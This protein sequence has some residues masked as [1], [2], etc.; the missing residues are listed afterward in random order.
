MNPLVSVITPC[1]NAGEKIIK[2]LDSLLEQTYNNLEIIIVDNGSIDNTKEIVISYK[3]IF[4]E[5]GY[6]FVLLQEK[7]RGADNALNLGLKFF[8]GKYLIWPDC[9]DILLPDNIK[10]KV[11]FLENNSNYGMVFC[12]A[13]IKK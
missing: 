10:E 2:F 11:I 12:N 1:Y 9:D 8:T 13:K 7:K 5:K 4:I 6:K 3:K